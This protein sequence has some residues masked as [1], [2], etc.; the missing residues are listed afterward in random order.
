MGGL[1][2]TH[3][4]W[5]CQ[6]L[7]VAF[8]HFLDTRQYGEVARLF[9]E[10]GTWQRGE[11]RLHGRGEIA[12][13]LR[14]RSTTRVS[15]HVLSNFLVLQEGEEEVEVI[16]TLT[17]YAFDNGT[18]VRLPQAIPAP[19]GIYSARAWLARTPAGIGLRRL[20]LAAEFTF[21]G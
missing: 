1:E 5:R 16:A 11:T 14:K 8:F 4:Q 7:L 17:T 21:S 6:Q 9:L 19:M 13:D 12:A 2:S 15:R 10:E 3:R 18:M 20:E